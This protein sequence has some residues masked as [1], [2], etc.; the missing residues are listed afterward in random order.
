MSNVL[1]CPMA[2]P[3]I[4]AVYADIEQLN[5]CAALTLRLMTEPVDT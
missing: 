2:N 5:R 4:T 1:A 3:H